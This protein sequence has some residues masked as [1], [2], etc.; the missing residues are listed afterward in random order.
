MPK[1]SVY[2]KNFLFIIIPWG[3]FVFTFLMFYCKLIYKKSVLHFLD[4]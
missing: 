3:K 4:K 2:V 1:I